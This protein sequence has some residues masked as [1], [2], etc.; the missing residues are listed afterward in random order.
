M[1]LLTLHV[2]VHLVLR[3]SH[4][5]I[6]QDNNQAWSSYKCST[7]VDGFLYFDHVFNN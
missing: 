7:T 1:F 6:A 5:T 4:G 2:R 3:I